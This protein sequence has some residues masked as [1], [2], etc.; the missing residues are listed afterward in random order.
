MN[1][2]QIRFFIDQKSSG[3]NIQL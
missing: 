1:H 3:R 2:M